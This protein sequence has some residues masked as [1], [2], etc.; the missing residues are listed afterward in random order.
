MFIEEIH[1]DRLIDHTI[2]DS[3]RKDQKGKIQ[4]PKTELVSFYFEIYRQSPVKSPDIKNNIYSGHG[5]T[6]NHATFKVHDISNN[7]CIF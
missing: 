4:L 6:M 1:P 7:C 2:T 5:D 3:K